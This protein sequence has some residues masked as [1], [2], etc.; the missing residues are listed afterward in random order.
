MTGPKAHIN[1]E[2][3]ANMYPKSFRGTCEFGFEAHPTERG[4]HPRADIRGASVQ[5]ASPKSV[6]LDLSPPARP[7]VYP[8]SVP[9]AALSVGDRDD[10]R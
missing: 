5:D 7:M 4:G 6:N 2:L 3:E 1:L 8:V 10:R 9:N